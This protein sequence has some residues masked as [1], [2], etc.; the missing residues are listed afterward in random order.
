MAAKNTEQTKVDSQEANA[1]K[2]QAPQGKTSAVK[3]QESVYTMEEFAV[4]AEA[5][6]GTSYECV[7]AALKEK[8][9]AQCTKAEAM[10][11]VK[12]FCGREV[13]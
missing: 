6:F 4:N 1:V 7:C 2:Q 13:Q 3:Q 12:A 9:I 5:I 8:G 10:E 11:V